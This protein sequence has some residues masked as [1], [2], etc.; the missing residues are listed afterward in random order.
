MNNATMAQ[1][2]YQAY[3]HSTGGKTWDGRDMPKYDDLPDAIKTAWKA[4]ADA[5]Y[6]EGANEARD[7]DRAAE[8]DRSNG[9]AG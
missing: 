8:K 4:A 2:A 3:A 9:G 6:Y 5:A 7:Q 1:A